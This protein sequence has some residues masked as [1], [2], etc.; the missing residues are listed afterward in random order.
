[1]K[2]GN[3][4]V[5][6]QIRVSPEE[7]AAIVRAAKNANLPMSAWILSKVLPSQRIKFHALV[8]ALK[9][10]KNS[11]Y[12]Y[13]EL[14]DLLSG[15]TPA[16]FSDT[17]AE[18]PDI[19]LP[20]YTENYLAAMVEHAAVKKKVAIPAWIRTIPPLK[21]PVFG[22]DLKSL[23]MHLLTQ[24]PCAFRSRNIFIDSTLGD[25]V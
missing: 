9:A 4:T 13:A 18:R 2:A 10:N 1:M 22:T 12:V 23:R 7:K 24:S 19:Q 11:A 16:L 21:R 15:L 17:V 14:N 25:R 20:A 8:N 6:L 5:H 3:K